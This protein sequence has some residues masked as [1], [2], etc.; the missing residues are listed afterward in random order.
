LRYLGLRGWMGYTIHYDPTLPWL[1]AAAV[2]AV[3]ALAAHFAEKF[4]ERPWNP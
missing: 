1:L 3:L 4:R 2:A